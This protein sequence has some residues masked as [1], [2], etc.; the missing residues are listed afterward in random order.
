MRPCSRQMARAASGAPP[1]PTPKLRMDSTS[2]ATSETALLERDAE[3]GALDGALAGAIEW[4]RQRGRDRGPARDREVEPAE[5]RPGAGTRARDVHAL[6]ARDR[7]GAELSVRHRAPDRR[8]GLARQDPGGARRPV[9]RRGEAG[10]ADTRPGH[11]RERGEP[12]ADV[13]AAARPLL[14]HR[15]P[16]ARAAARDRDRRRPVGRRGVD[17]RRALPQPADRGPPDGAAPRGAPHRGGP[18]RGPAGRDAGRPHHDPDPARPT[19]RGSGPAAGGGPPRVGRPGLR[20]RLPQRHRR[21]PVPARA[22][23]ER[24]ARGGHRAHRRERRERGVA[25]P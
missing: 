18:A 24:G 25:R 3:L 20:G 22:A 23:R 1:N 6:G 5:P 21:Q 7:A 8:L 14:A 12:G 10:A 4:P 15:E 9:H 2:P 11:E 19:V 13:P 16:G 17:G